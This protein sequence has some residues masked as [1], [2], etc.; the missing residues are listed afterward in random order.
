M[1]VQ[2]KCD[3]GEYHWIRYCMTTT[4]NSDPEKKTPGGVG[5]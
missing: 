1:L 3:F 2:T 5:F 4:I